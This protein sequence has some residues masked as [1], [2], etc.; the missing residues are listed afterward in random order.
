MGASGC[1]KTTLIS[2]VVGMCTI[3]SGTIKVFDDDVGRNN[4]RIGYMPQE[5]ALIQEFSIREI[6]NFFGTIFGL[7]KDN[8]VD[9]SIFLEKLL[10]LPDQNK[11][12]QKCS[13]GQQRR[14]SLAVA[15][16][17]DPEILILDEPTVGVDPLLRARIWDFLVDLTKIKNTTIF[18]TT[19][20]I[21][22]AKNSTH[23]GLMRKGVLV[24]E[25]TP[26]NLLSMFQTDRLEEAFLKL[27]E[28]QEAAPKVY[29]YRQLRAKSE[30]LKKQRRNNTSTSNGSKIR[31][32]IMKNFVQ[33]TRNPGL[34]SKL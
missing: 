32:L 6:L 20:Y 30:K 28:R 17:H 34:V 12:I 27:S 2:C 16:L 1:G 3:D 9:R 14:V 24:A 4:A 18:M 23:V 22:E 31:A 10:D 13:G 15:L 21:E 5:M 7:T 25:D 33:L 19:H 29:G 11:I 8:I 26:H